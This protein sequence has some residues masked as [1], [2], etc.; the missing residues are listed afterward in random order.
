[1]DMDLNKGVSANVL[2]FKVIGHWPCGNKKFYNIYTRFVMICM[3]LYNV[4]GLIYLFKNLD[5]AE[6]VSATIYN[7]LSTIAVVLKV[8]FFHENHEQ[9]KN[10]VKTFQIE[11]F[12]PITDEQRKLLKSGI[13]LAKFI[14]Y[15]FFITADLTLVMWLIFPILDKERRLPSKA[16]F[17]Y[18]YLSSEYYIF[19][20]IWQ[21]IFI[22]YHALTNVAMD[23]L[24]SILMIQTG[25]Q[26]DILNVKVTAFNAS[27]IMLLF[28]QLAIFTQIFL[29]CWFGNEV[30]LKVNYLESGKIYYSLYVSNWYECPES[31]KKDLLFFMH[32]AQKPIILFVGNMFPVSLTTFT[33]N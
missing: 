2:L 23:T 31:F 17:P 16:W 9:V 20:Y 6:E 4:S 27:Y 21:G 24:F 11:E 7:L 14:F 3:Y 33:S 29:Y 28:Y 12:Q 5:D 10:I 18:D 1:M 8:N 26:C 30:V 13:F 22:C 25:A 19:T 32:R 15:Y